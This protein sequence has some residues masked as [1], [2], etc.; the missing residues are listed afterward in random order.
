MRN[1]NGMMIGKIK[2]F[3]LFFFFLSGLIHL[4]YEDLQRQLLK[5]MR[6]LLTKVI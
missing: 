3:N 1:D 2:A 5:E 6:K 4:S